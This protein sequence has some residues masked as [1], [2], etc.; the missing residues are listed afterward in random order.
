LTQPRVAAEVVEQSILI[1]AEK[2]VL[3]ERH[4]LLERTIQQ[5]D[6]LQLE[7]ARL[8]DNFV[9]DPCRRPVA[10]RRSPRRSPVLS[11]SSIGNPCRE[12]VD[13]AADVRL[14]RILG[15][16]NSSV[17]WTLVSGTARMG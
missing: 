12:A 3:I 8:E 10:S 4:R 7:R 9:R 16:Q 17:T 5:P 14:V 13:N 1:E 2:I 11:N 6:V 15:A